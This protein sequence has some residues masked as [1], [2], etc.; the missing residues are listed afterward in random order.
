MCSNRL[1]R[2]L[3][4][5][6]RA[7]QLGQGDAPSSPERLRAQ[8]H[9]RPPPLGWRRRRWRSRWWRWRMMWAAA[10][11]V[12]AQGWPA[13]PLCGRPLAGLLIACDDGAAFAAHWRGGGGGA[14]EGTDAGAGEGSGGGGGGDTP[15]ARPL[16]RART[17]AAAMA[18]AAAAAAAALSSPGAAAAAFVY[19]RAG[20]PGFDVVGDERRLQAVRPNSGRRRLPKHGLPCHGRC[21]RR[22]RGW[23]VKWPLAL[24]QG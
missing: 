8:S 15:S 7:R 4:G 1:R 9:E 19:R 3:A 24:A 11:T 16:H 22:E 5:C 2:G 20:A 10:A 6:R 14:R 21:W 18:V 13:R 17:G 23:R 12:A